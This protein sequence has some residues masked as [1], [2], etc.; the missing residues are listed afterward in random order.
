MALNVIPGL[1]II[2]ERLSFSHPQPCQKQQATFQKSQQ[3][4][5]DGFLVPTHQHAISMFKT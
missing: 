2:H 1:A 4:D 3:S 5:Y